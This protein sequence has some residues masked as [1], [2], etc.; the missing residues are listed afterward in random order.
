MSH[1]PCG[2]RL[3]L[4]YGLI[5]AGGNAGE[6]GAEIAEGVG[7]LVGNHVHTPHLGS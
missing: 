3:L 5:T 4:W 6:K 2:P 7:V 1:V